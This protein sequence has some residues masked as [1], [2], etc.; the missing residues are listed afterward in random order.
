MSEV[1]IHA[2][3]PHPE[4]AAVLVTPAGRLPA[5]TVDSDDDIGPRLAALAKEHG[6]TSPFLRR[7]ASA[8]P[9]GYD[10]ILK[11]FEP[12]PAEGRD[13]LPVADLHRLDLPEQLRPGLAQWVEL[14]NAGTRHDYR[15]AWSRPGWYTRTARWFADTLA[16]HGIEAVDDP[17]IVQQWA[18]SA[19]LRQPTRSHGDH[20]LKS[21][22]GSAGR[23]FWHEPALSAALHRELP[24]LVPEVTAIDEQRG[25]MVMPDMRITLVD[26]KPPQQWASGLPT[27]ARIQRHW[28]GRREQLLSL[29]CPDRGPD[30]LLE[31]LETALADERLASAATPQQRERMTALMPVFRRLCDEAADWPVPLSLGHGD[32]HPGN[33]GIRADGETRVFDWSDGAW[34][35]PFFDVPLY[36]RNLPD[37]ELRD[38]AWN[39]YLECFSDF[40]PVS[41]LRQ[42]IPAVNV[43]TALYQVVTFRG[44]IDNLAPEDEFVFSGFGGGFWE[45]TFKVFDAEV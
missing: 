32:C 8:G 4:A 23:G 16:E 43:L 6:I 35:H 37:A 31:Q 18:I 22:F 12:L 2:V 14:H 7:V 29:G 11:E 39:T 33:V 5:V 17:A 24:G 9:N 28:I 36:V 44:I 1:V 15:P 38:A 3:V 26:A 19:V 20:Y 34:T 40:A 25:L 10:L 42:L 45:R 27:L 13:W 21:V 41:E 30:S